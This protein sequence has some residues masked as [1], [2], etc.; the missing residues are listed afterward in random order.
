MPQLSGSGALPAATVLIAEDSPT[1]AA[2]LAHLL[3]QRG[4]RVLCAGDGAAALDMVRR[5]RPDLLV[6]DIIMPAMDGYAL[7]RAVKSDPALRSTPVILVTE[8]SS[9]HDVFRGLDAGADNFIV[10][11]YDDDLLT[12]RVNYL[13]TNLAL[14]KSGTRQ[15]GIEIELA[16]QRH[17]I[18]ADRQ[19]ILDLLISTYEQAMRLYDELE[20]RQRALRRS[21]DTLNALYHLADGL[22]RCHGAAD[23]GAVAL[24]RALKLPGVGGGWIDLRRDGRFERLAALGPAAPAV[25]AGGAACPCAARLLAGATAAAADLTGCPC[26][27]GAGRAG[28]ARA[29]AGVPLLADGAVIGLLHLVG[30]DGP[31]FADDELQTFS[32]IG[33]QIATALARALLHEEMERKVGERT[34]ELQAEV[35]E[36]RDAE[37]AARQATEEFR[38][39]NQ[40]ISAIL[41]ASPVG[42][43]AVDHDGLVRTWNYA[44]EAIFGHAA[45][46]TVGRP[47]PGLPPELRMALPADPVHRWLAA[48]KVVRNAEHAGR[49]KD[50]AAVSLRVSSAPLA[51]ATGCMQGTV[52]VV[53]DVS[54]RKRI[55]EQLH[56]SQKMEAIGNLTGGIAHD[57]NNMLAVVIGNLD[58]VGEQLEDRPQTAE[59]VAAALQASLRGADLTRRLLAFSR[60]QPLAP[61]TVDV[62]RLIR[63][64]VKLLARTLGEQ[65]EI[66]FLEAA[67]LWS[68]KVDPGQLDSAILNLAVN[69]RDAM[70]EGGRLTL[71]TRNQSVDADF[72]R[73][74]PDIAPGDYIVI[75]VSD[76]GT[77]IPP[78]L[79]PRVFEPFFTTKAANQGTGLGLAMVY[80]FVK[81]SGG[82]V[83]VYS[84][85]GHGTTFRLYLPRVGAAEAGAADAAAPAETPLG[86]GGETVLVVEDDAAVR[87]MV[88]QQLS[89]LG[90]RVLCA[91]DAAA[92]LALLEGGER[93]DLLFT[94]VVMPGDLNGVGLAREASRRWPGL[95]V[96]LTSGFTE[97]ALGRAGDAGSF[98]ILNKPYRRVDLARLLRQTLDG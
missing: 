70:P 76:S 37:T 95:R 74:R 24:D 67:D 51:D 50:G 7:C 93:I 31:P 79:L 10:K 25:A 40:T 66:R 28:Q 39:A 75:D 60:R 3:E 98:P 62:N 69:A 65:V 32:G 68:A 12:A 78:D 73:T 48:G 16:G 71:Q 38:Q 94:D 13:M 36:R 96:A 46:E 21:Y 80:G 83:A 91:G 18:T 22:N 30:V 15:Q 33:N 64:V 56:Q 72:S 53:E 44:A 8:L 45:A 41:E 43:V 89:E 85:L 58:L 77:G 35:E 55:E 23:V 4:F 82:H 27:A 84:E 6:S 63:G 59:L 34:R 26:L 92:G 86:R 42:I 29:H 1:Q 61:E 54:E 47:M 49:R 20:D 5:H 97:A 90:Y 9:S 2:Q 81:Q 88:R 52:L 11:P 19:Q 17:F 14:R 87:S 57:F